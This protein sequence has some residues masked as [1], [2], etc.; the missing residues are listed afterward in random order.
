MTRITL[1]DGCTWEG[2]LDEN[3]V[4]NGPGVKTYPNGA[5][6]TGLWV[7]D[8]RHG[9]GIKTHA[10]G[11]QKAVRYEHGTLITAE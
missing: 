5:T 10:D 9:C 8:V 6:Y 1:E 4:R 7:D 3:G 2:I 11:T